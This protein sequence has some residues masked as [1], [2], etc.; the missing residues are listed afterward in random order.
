MRA[1]RVDRIPVAELACGLSLLAIGADDGH[2]SDP[3]ALDQ[4]DHA[5]VGQVW[6]GQLGHAGKR[7]LVVERRREHGTRL[8]EEREGAC[9]QHPFPRSLAQ[10][11]PPA[12][13]AFT[14]H[15]HMSPNRRTR[16]PS[17]AC[18]R[19]GNAVSPARARAAAA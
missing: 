9:I 16:Q 3:L 7:R 17:F 8:G 1:I 13:R 19:G 2:P 6:N 5:P 15:G 11:A 14:L 18:F 10:Q 4:V 12:A